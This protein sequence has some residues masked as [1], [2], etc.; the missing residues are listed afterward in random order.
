MLPKILFGH[1][2]IQVNPG[3][4]YRYYSMDLSAR[5]RLGYTS[6]YAVQTTIQSTQDG[7]FC[8]A[9]D[10]KDIVIRIDGSA[11]EDQEAVELKSL[12]SAGNPR[13]YRLVIESP[14]GAFHIKFVPLDE[15]STRLIKRACERRVQEGMGGNIVKEKEE[16]N[17]KAP[18]STAT[19]PAPTEQKS[20]VDK[21]A[22]QEETKK[23]GSISSDPDPTAAAAIDAFATI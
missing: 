7:Y 9:T 11:Y 12:D 16:V 6:P 22:V 19:T 5:V 10:R 17:I 23:K 3:E 2:F 20:T 4:P 13:L 21:K 14:G 15:K 8:I 18:T 1:S